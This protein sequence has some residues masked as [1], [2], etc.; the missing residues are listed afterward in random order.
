MKRIGILVTSMLF[1]LVLAFPQQFSSAFAQGKAEIKFTETSFDFGKIQEADG[2]ASHEFTFTNTGDAP[3]VLSRVTASCGCTTPEYSKEPIAPGKK[4]V[5]K[6]TYGAKGRPGMFT[7]TISV[8]T[9]V[10]EAP[11]TLTIKGEVIPIPPKE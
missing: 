5:I 10:Q 3:L 9:N 11:I 6:A 7:K 2:D 1:G 4:G 8:Y